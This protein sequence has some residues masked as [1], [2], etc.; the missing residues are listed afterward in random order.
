MN[1]PLFSAS[2]LSRAVE[3]RQDKRPQP[4]TCASR[5]ACPAMRKSRWPTAQPCRSARW[6]A[7]RVSP[8]ARSTPGRRRSSRPLSAPRSAPGSSRCSA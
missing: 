6:P 3:S 8:C 7:V 2:Q 1:V 4:P 5:A